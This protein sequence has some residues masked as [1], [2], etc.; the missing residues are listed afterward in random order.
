MAERFLRCFDAARLITS[1]EASSAV[2]FA[3]KTRDQSTQ[4]P[5]FHNM[6]W[7][8]KQAARLGADAISISDNTDPM[9]ATKYYAIIYK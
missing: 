6:I 7:A 1:G 3:S 4:N 5:V 2:Q 9:K 8:K